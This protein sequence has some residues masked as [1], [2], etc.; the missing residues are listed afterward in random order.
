MSND[1]IESTRHLLATPTGL[2]VEG[3]APEQEWEDFGAALARAD[4]ALQWLIGDWY[5]QVP[6]GDKKAACERVGLNYGSAKKYG[7]IAGKYEMRIRIHNCAFAHH[8]VAASLPA[9]QR[10]EVLEDAAANNWTVRE[11]RAAVKEK[12]NPSKPRDE[13]DIREKLHELADGEWRTRED[14][15]DA[16]EMDHSDIGS[17]LSTWKRRGDYDLLFQNRINPETKE[18]EWCMV[19]P[20]GRTVDVAI[21][22]KSIRPALKKIRQEA[23]KGQARINPAY[24]L[25]YLN[26]LEAA[27]QELID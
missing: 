26:E 16:L 7:E 17:K 13:M 18:R 11:V 27:I 14:I 1:M 8:Q 9:P 12:Q 19:L 25:D 20:E 10:T 6:W 4:K 24:I 23:K 3:D 15:A 2:V 5:N 21:L 22:L